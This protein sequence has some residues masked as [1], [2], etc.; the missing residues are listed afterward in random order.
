MEGNI[1]AEDQ[2]QRMQQVCDVPTRLGGINGRHHHVRK[3]S[4][5]EHEG[6]NEEEHQPFSLRA[7]IRLHYVLT[8]SNGI[9]PGNKNEK[10]GQYVPGHFHD[11]HGQDKYLPGVGLG[12]A[13]SG[14]VE[15]ALVDV[16]RHDL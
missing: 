14:F 1:P 9:V 7:L 15:R 12:R 2:R 4:R 10:R 8:Q 6:K 3:S 5:E 13:L 16:V 11:R